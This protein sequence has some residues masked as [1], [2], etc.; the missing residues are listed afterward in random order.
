MFINLR[1]ILCLLSCKHFD[2]DWLDYLENLISE[3]HEQFIKLFGPLKPKHHFMLHYRHIIVLMG[4]LV[5][6][7]AIRGESR[8]REGKLTSNSV[9]TRV[10]ICHTIALKQ[11]LMFSN[12]LIL[13]KGFDSRFSS[14][15]LKE[16]SVEITNKLVNQTSYVPDDFFM[17]DTVS[18]FG[19]TYRNNFT[20]VIEISEEFPIF[21]KIQEILIST[22]ISSKGFPN[23][24]DMF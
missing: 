11:Q 4:P 8:N 9:A 12:R 3:H 7:Q 6:L 10:N 24:G 16:L 18:I 23:K 2:T 22:K 17:V 14:G 13:N 1:Q 15:R 21:A 5:H 20:I 19:T